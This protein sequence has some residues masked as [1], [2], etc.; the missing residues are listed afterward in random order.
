LGKFS[1]GLN[2][3][4]HE[5]PVLSYTGWLLEATLFCKT[6]AVLNYQFGDTLLTGFCSLD[7]V[8]HLLFLYSVKGV[9]NPVTKAAVL[10]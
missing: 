8:I 1:G 6:F 5:F 9:A 7:A 4:Y 3:F 2:N 10:W